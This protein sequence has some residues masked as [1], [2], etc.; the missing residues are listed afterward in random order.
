MAG[1]CYW[2]LKLGRYGNIFK[3][4]SFLSLCFPCEKNY[5]NSKL[6]SDPICLFSTCWVKGKS[7]RV[8]AN[9]LI[10]FEENK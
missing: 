2:G 1:I 7:K 8:S 6:F 5:W 9:V 10:E 3:I 4:I